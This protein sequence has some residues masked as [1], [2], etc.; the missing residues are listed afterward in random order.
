MIS[1]MLTDLETLS[2]LKKKLRDPLSSEPIKNQNTHL[3][4]SHLGITTFIGS[5]RGETKVSVAVK[6]L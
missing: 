4:L 3:R 2:T 5:Q 1:K 6:V